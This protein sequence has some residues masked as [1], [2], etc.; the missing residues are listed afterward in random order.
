MVSLP[1]LAVPPCARLCS[2]TRLRQAE[3]S[4]QQRLTLNHRASGRNAGHNQGHKNVPLLSLTRLDTAK[5][6]QRSPL[7]PS[8]VK[9]KIQL[10]LIISQ[11]VLSC[12]Y[13]PVKTYRGEDCASSLPPTPNLTD[14][15]FCQQCGTLSRLSYL[16]HYSAKNLHSTSQ[17]E[18]FPTQEKKSAAAP[19]TAKQKLKSAPL[20]KLTLS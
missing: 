15:A 5:E 9:V 19:T 12:Q 18:D 11:D 16:F 8:L 3:K 4:K 20:S 13:D 2:G 17:G 7:L 6:R 10:S 1:G 14:S